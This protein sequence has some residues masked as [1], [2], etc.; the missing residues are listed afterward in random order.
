MDQTVSASGQGARAHRLNRFDWF[1]V[2][3]TT[4]LAISTLTT[5]FTAE[6]EFGLYA[7]VILIVGALAWKKLRRFEYP[8][9]LIV[10]VQVG[11]I[12]H[13][14]GGY[15][16]YGPEGWLYWHYFFGIRYDQI[17]HFYNSFVGVLG[18]GI[19]SRQSAVDFGRAEPIILVG[20][21]L[22][23]GALIEIVEYFAKLTIPGVG[24]GDYDNN[25]QDLVLNLAGGIT[26]V[27]LERGLRPLAA[28]LRGRGSPASGPPA[29]ADDGS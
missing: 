20:L 29:D 13:F 12:A 17:V 21:V 14:S 25:M 18:F 15:V 8:W 11:I 24:V 5:Y 23:A 10:L 4:A 22:G 19:I 7:A 6:W 28:L 27:G 3:N 2:V 1:M 26:A 16:K 9:W